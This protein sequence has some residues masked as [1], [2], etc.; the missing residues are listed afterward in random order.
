MVSDKDSVSS[1]SLRQV[2]IMILSDI[3]LVNKDLVSYRLSFGS[4][5]GVTK[6]QRMEALGMIILYQVK[7][8]SGWNYPP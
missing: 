2:W 6:T 1:G 3:W 4:T 7:F 5:I 8:Q